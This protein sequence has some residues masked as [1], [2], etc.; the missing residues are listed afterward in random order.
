MKELLV[1]LLESESAFKF[2]KIHYLVIHPTPGGPSHKLGI[3]PGDKIIKI[4]KETVAG[5]G[6]KNSGV[7]KRLVRRQR[8]VL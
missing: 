8:D 6:L 3:L 4:D 1:V 7:R 5:T 2:T